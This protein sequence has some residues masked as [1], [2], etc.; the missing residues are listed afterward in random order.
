MKEGEEKEKEKLERRGGKRAIY[1]QMG[2]LVIWI[3]CGIGL[4]IVGFFCCEREKVNEKSRE[5]VANHWYHPWNWLTVQRVS[6]HINHLG[7]DTAAEVEMAIDQK[8]PYGS[9]V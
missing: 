7:G 5:I 4:G 8:D 9:V 3:N 2:R 1:R 6:P